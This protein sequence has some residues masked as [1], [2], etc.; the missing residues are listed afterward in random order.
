[1]SI[2]RIESWVVRIP[3][4]WPIELGSMRFVDR[5]YTVLRITDSNGVQGVAFGMARN[6]PVLG[7]IRTLAPLVIGRDTA[8]SERLWSDLY[9]ASVPHGQRGVSLRALSLIDI[10]VWDIRST[11]AGLPLWAMLGGFRREAQVI[12][13]GGYFRDR[14]EPDEVAE[15]L[16]GY[17]GDG[18]TQVKIPMGGLDPSAEEQWVSAAR[19][20]VGA[21]VELAVD[22]HWTYRTVRSAR[23]VLERLDQ[24]ALAWIEDPLWPEAIQAAAE[25]RRHIRS[26]IAIGDELSGRWVYDD[27][28]R[29][30][31]ADIWRA[32]VTTVGGFTEFRR[33]AA[34]AETHGTPISTHIYPELHVHCALAFDSVM[35]VEYTAPDADIDLSHRFVVNPADPVQGI[36]GAPKNPGLGIDLDWDVVEAFAAERFE[37]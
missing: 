25:L 9:V 28:H 23:R 21:E 22:A 7:A 29:S 12:V 2:E 30:G 35:G 4:R 27:L 1:M 17:V 33:I 16:R 11:V 10:A 8:D 26:P 24:F 31:A 32:D 20:A 37:T 15:E 6:A 13:G 18:F 34:L 5:D 36:L 19:E 3:L 14:R